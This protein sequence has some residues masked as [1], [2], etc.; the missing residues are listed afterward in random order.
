MREAMLYEKLPDRSVVCHLCAHRCRVRPGRMGVCAVRE[1]RGGI[2]YTWVHDRIAASAVDP[3]EK[4]P[5]FHFLP[6]SKTFSIAT[7]GCNFHCRY[8]Q[9]WDI[10]QTP[11]VRRRHIPGSKTSPEE[12]V[13]EAKA[14]GCKSVAYTYSEP[15]IFLELAVETARLARHEGLKNIFVTD[16]Y[17]TPEGLDVI[18]PWLDA[19]NVDLKAFDETTHRALCGARLQP[20]LD[21]ITDIRARGIWT[22]VTTTLV[23]GVNDSKSELTALAGFIRSV[24]SA[25]PWHVASLA[26]AYLMSDHAP[27]SP[28][29]MERAWKIGKDTGLDYVYCFGVAT[30]D[31][32][33]T[34]CPRCNERLVEREGLAVTRMALDNAHCPS[35]D[36]PVAG[37]WQ[38]APVVASRGV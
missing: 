7:V 14:S 16:G 31:H 2:L 10:S 25:I 6:G 11:K 24:D 26:P 8:C 5:L 4:K 20:V 27:T 23:P 22:E 12:I 29:A 3:V 9:T 34:L 1:N 13:A 15:T 36:A 19:A 37:V 35:C 17:I 18:A 32:G 21:G 28:Q 30:E 33:N 38:E